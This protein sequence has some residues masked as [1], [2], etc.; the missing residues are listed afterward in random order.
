MTIQSTPNMHPQAV[1]ANVNRQHQILTTAAYALGTAA[2][3]I[4]TASGYARNAD[5]PSQISWAIVGAASVAIS[6]YAPSALRQALRASNKAS[7][8]A[9]T[10]AYT[11]ALLMCVATALGSASGNRQNASSSAQSASDAQNRAQASYDTAQVELARMPVT[12]SQ[13]EITAEIARVNVRIDGANC[14]SWVKDSDARKVCSQRDVLNIELARAT[15]KTTLHAESANA[16]AILDIKPTTPANSDATAIA[17]YL[18]AIGINT[19]PDTVS[20]WLVLLAVALLDIA[21]GLL[22]SAIAAPRAQ[23]VQSQAADLLIATPSGVQHAVTQPTTPDGNAPVQSPLKPMPINPSNTHKT[24]VITSVQPANQSSPALTIERLKRQIAESLIAG[25]KSV[26]QRQLASEL[27]ASVGSVNTAI[28]E[29][30]SN[31][32]LNVRADRFG[33]KLELVS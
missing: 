12:R 28:R 3:F 23:Q 25:P 26:S 27:N 29:L 2:L 7:A 32:K 18:A 24:P 8:A 16:A 21:P 22:L 33:T 30:A 1:D 4:A 10:A 17:A 19:S 5:L 15:R 11:L 9:L 13:A 20:K 6:F 14:S 31:G